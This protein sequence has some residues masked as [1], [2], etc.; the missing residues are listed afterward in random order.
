[1]Q[2]IRIPLFDE[3]GKPLKLPAL[4]QSL[5][6]SLPKREEGE[7]AGKLM[8][9]FE[10]EPTENL[11]FSMFTIQAAKYG[12]HPIFRTVL[13][14]LR[15]ND[16]WLIL[17]SYVNTINE[18]YNGTGV[19]LVLDLGSTS[20]KAR[21]K[22]H[23]DGVVSIAET[24]KMLTKLPPLKNGGKIV[25]SFQSGYPIDSDK[26]RRLFSPDMFCVEIC[27]PKDEPVLPLDNVEDIERAGYRLLD[28]EHPEQVLEEGE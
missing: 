13:P 10:G 5:A 4:N 14:T 25:L 15:E 28:A 7:A 20:E 22:L 3:A 11:A 19:T 1:M 12:L 21:H 2:S 23:P 8:L 18:T 26:L 9:D 16:L 27:M 24:A 6:E 17:N